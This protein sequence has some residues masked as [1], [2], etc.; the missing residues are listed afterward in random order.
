MSSRFEE[1]TDDEPGDGFGWLAQQGV[2]LPKY[3]PSLQDPAFGQYLRAVLEMGRDRR[4]TIPGAKTA[5]DLHHEFMQRYMPSMLF[6][7][8]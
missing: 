4:T 1:I 6:Q 5:E 2:R 7:E 8:R 3:M